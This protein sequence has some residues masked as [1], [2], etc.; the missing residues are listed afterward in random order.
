M[1][2]WSRGARRAGRRAAALAAAWS[3]RASVTSFGRQRLARRP[4]RALVLAAAALGARGE[5]EQAL[6]GEVLDGADPEAGVVGKV[7]QR[8]EVDRAR[9]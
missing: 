6:P 8:R 9:R 3:R 5:V 2:E 1:P 7:L 4:R